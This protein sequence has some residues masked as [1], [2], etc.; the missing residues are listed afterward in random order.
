MCD[1]VGLIG[2]WNFW[3]DGLLVPPPLHK[4]KS[5]EGMIHTD[6]QNIWNVKNMRSEYLQYSL[7]SSANWNPAVWQF[8]QLTAVGVIYKLTS[9]SS[10]LSISLRVKNCIDWQFKLHIHVL[11][12]WVMA[13]ICGILALCTEIWNTESKIIWVVRHT[14]QNQRRWR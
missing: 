13:N 11:Y 8:I 6:N 10:I 9:S 12:T 3:Q 7:D 4:R 2:K 1:F 5:L 14:N